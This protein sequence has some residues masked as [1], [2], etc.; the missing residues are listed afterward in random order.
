MGIWNVKI[1]DIEGTRTIEIDGSSSPGSVFLIGEF[2]YCIE[3]D[4][5]TLLLAIAVE[6]GFSESVSLGAERFLEQAA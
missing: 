1:N 3:V 2:G 4:R 5:E 6:V